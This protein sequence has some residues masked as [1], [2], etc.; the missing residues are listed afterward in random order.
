MREIYVSTDVETDGPI[1][2][3]HSMLSLGSAAY[4]ADK[5]RLSMFSANLETLPGASAHPETAAWWLT[6]PDA[7]AAC[8]TDLQ[9]PHDA[10][11]AYLVWLRALPGKP[12]FVAYPAG[13]DFTFMHWYLV[14][15][16]GESPFS[17]SALDVKSFAMALLGTRFRDT[18]KQRMPRAWFGPQRHTHV[19]LDDAREQGALF[20]G[21]LR[22][23]KRRLTSP[24]P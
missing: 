14:R 12:V 10:M 7:W 11:H 3:P 9:D 20:M 15:F 5:Q 4:T 23:S 1:P 13:F 22:E 19:A 8:R 2:G 18:A 16:T 21:M 24:E 17:H 6:Q